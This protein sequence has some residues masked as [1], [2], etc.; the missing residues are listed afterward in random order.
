MKRNMF[1]EMKIQ[2]GDDIQALWNDEFGTTDPNIVARDLED[3]SESDMG[4][5][6]SLRD[7]DYNESECHD[8]ESEQA[9]RDFLAQQGVEIAA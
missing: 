7:D 4:W 9:L 3:D 1:N 2:P 5:T 8:F 6:C